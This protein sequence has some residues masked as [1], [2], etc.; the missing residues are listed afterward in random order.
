LRR[1]DVQAAGLP[2][3]ACCPVTVERSDTWETHDLRD[4]AKTANSLEISMHAG[5]ETRLVE[6][7]VNEEHDNVDSD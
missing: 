1:S 3:D 7:M 5:S 2:L 6:S 4:L